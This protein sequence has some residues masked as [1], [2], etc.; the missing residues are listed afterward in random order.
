MHRHK[1]LTASSPV[2]IFLAITLSLISCKMTKPYGDAA[3]PAEK[4]FRDQSVT[5]TANFANLP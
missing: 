2:V 4:S 5:D 1:I 3:V